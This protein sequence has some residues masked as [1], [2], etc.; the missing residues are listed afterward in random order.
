MEYETLLTIQGYAKFGLLTLTFIV[1]YSYAYSIY[2][3]DKSGDR[4][5]ESYSNLVL[6]DNIESKPLENNRTEINKLEKNK[7]GDS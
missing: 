4:D 6:D 3:R 5:F 1:F 7:K 2:K